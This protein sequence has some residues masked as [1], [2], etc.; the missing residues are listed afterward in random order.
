VSPKFLKPGLKVA[1][2][3]LATAPVLWGQAPERTLFKDLASDD[4]R[5]EVLQAVLASPFYSMRG[6]FADKE[7]AGSGYGGAW[8]QARGYFPNNTYFVR[9]GTYFMTHGF[10]P[11]GKLFMEVH[12]SAYLSLGVE[13][14]RTFVAGS[15][16]G[17]Y[18]RMR[19]AADG[20]EAAAFR[21]K[22]GRL[23]SYFIDEPANKSLRKALGEA[24]YGR[25]LEGLRAEDYHMLA[26]GLTHE[27]M[28]AGLDDDRL[29]AGI[30]AEYKAGGLPVQWDELRAYMA[31]FGYH[32]PFCRWAV[33][34][35]A[36]I[37]KQVE[38]RLKGL[39]ALRNKPRLARPSD[40]AKF[41][42]ARAGIGA[43]TAL[44]RLRM[45][46]VWQ[47]AQRM[48]GLLDGF[49]KDY[50]G[51]DPPADVDGPVGK[52][53]AETGEYV[54]DAGEAIPR[55]EGALR[56]LEETLDQWN[57]WAGGRRPFPPPVTDSNEILKRTKAT[58]WPV[59]PGNGVEALI[60]KAE[61]QIA[62]L[63]LDKRFSE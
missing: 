31:E 5:K 50:I 35:I 38:G 36:A 53:A 57:A 62:K 23:E 11:G 27:G 58:P 24:L 41:E 17:E 6:R 39:E 21:D 42:A 28:H 44:I 55:T 47:S 12:E 14:R 25:L 18:G 9:P 43:F 63:S 26:G 33:G 15:V 45:R 4:P 52:L 29:V 56:L 2:F 20:R 32:R 54:H 19:G 46:E 8:E 51:P 16:V 3:I 7:W 34:D 60:K 61:R 37:W 40:K 10:G 13:N 22:V 49:R 1:L 30:Q 59:P 48:Q